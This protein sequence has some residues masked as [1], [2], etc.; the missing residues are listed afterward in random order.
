MSAQAAGRAPTMPLRELVRLYRSLAG[1]FGAPVALS[2]F[3][4][5]KASRGREILDRRNPC[6]ACLHRRRNPVHPLI[7][8]PFRGPR[9]DCN[10]RFDLSC[11]LIPDGFVFSDFRLKNSRF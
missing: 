11:T 1:N 3:G 5:T 8:D 6:H 10:R 2:G 9:A 4:L 7:A